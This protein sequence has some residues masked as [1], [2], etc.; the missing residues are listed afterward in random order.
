[1]HLRT[2]QRP[3]VADLF[4]AKPQCLLSSLNTTARRHESSYRRTKQRLNIAPDQ[5]FIA[6]LGALQDHIIFNPPSSSPSV[7]HTP[8]KFLPQS[9]QRRKLL[10]TTQ[11]R[12]N[13]F[14]PRLPP[15]VDPKQLKYQKH[16]LSED[17]VAEIKRLRTNDPEK[18]TR[19]QLAKKFNCSSIFIGM[20]T[21]ASDDKRELERQKL[22]AVKARWGPTRTAARENRQRRIEMAKRDE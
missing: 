11:E 12:I 1:M 4:S 3:A 7:F 15:A 14:S 17:D 6:S 19:R 5:N 10:A 8:L 21:H 9:D 16:H 18:W 22:E 13:A 20:I 2:L